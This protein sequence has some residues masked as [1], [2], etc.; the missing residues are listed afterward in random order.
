V[1]RVGKLVRP[2]CEDRHIALSSGEV[3]LPDPFLLGIR[4][5]AYVDM[6]N[7][8]VDDVASD[9]LLAPVRIR[10]P[11]GHEL[12]AKM[13]IGGWSSTKCHRCGARFEYLGDAKC[14]RSNN[15]S[16]SIPGKKRRFAV[17]TTI[18]FRTPEGV[19]EQQ[20]MVLHDI[21]PEPGEL[22]HLRQGHRFS[23]SRGRT[24]VYD[25]ANHTVGERWPL[26]LQFSWLT[27][28]LRI[29]PIFLAGW[30]LADIWSLLAGVITAVI[31]ALVLAKRYGDRHAVPL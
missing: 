5:G 30:L 31:V 28:I 1:L 15:N 4:I 8:V 10:C 9:E 14:A 7:T 22:V 17:H 2:H 20:R 6:S 26:L 16:K 29:I 12:A 3:A 27:V 11:R 13:T 18:T 25:L 19:S 23:C 24:G 21:R